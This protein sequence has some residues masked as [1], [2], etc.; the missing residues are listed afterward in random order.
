MLLLDTAGI[1]PADRIEAVNSAANSAGLPSEVTH[2]QDGGEVR[3][4]VENWQLGSG[5]LF[6]HDSEGMKLA[7]STRNVRAGA[8]ERVVI[9]L[10]MSSRAWFTQK[11]VEQVVPRGDLMLVDHRYPYE[12]GWFGPGHPV[13]YQVGLDVLGLPDTTVRRAAQQLPASP[14]F[15][16]FRSHL[17]QVASVADDLSTSAYAAD[18]AGHTTTNLLRALLVTA[19]DEG[20][21]PTAPE[22]EIA[23][24]LD[25]A[26]HHVE[27]RGLSP[28]QIAAA[29][30]MSERHLYALCRNADISLE[31]WII[32]RR[33]ELARA[34][35]ASPVGKTRTIAAIAHSCGFTDP[36][37]FSRRFR[38]TYGVTPRQWQRV[39]RQSPKPGGGDG[40][41]PGED[42]G[43]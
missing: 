3:I 8:P 39:A 18:T 37:H 19:A 27:D 14:Y 29:L 11:G 7:R 26:R 16:I 42:A 20:P 32:Q 15:T 31:Q 23:R 17:N 21:P 35:L 4:R 43:N 13:S 36:A 30:N 12:F 38:E 40:R 5:M 34:R 22:A 9:S 33:L 28:R 6:A 41:D 1:P 2:A 24:I 10:Q 25:H